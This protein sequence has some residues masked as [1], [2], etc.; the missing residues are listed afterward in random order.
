MRRA[1]NT[2]PPKKAITSEDLGKLLAIEPSMG[3]SEI[4]LILDNEA[5]ETDPS[6]GLFCGIPQ[7][8]KFQHWLSTNESELLFVQDN[9]ASLDPKRAS[10]LSVFC[11]GLTRNLRE[12]HAVISIQFFCGHHAMQ[13]SN[14][15]L[16]GPAGLIRS[17]IFQ[18]IR[19]SGYASFDLGFLIPSKARSNIDKGDVP[20]LCWVFEKLVK[21][22]PLDTLLFCFV[23][24][25]SFFEG[26][27]YRNETMEAIECLQ[28]I[29]QDQKLPSI[30]KLMITH[31]S[32]NGHRQYYIDPQDC[33]LLS[34]QAEFEGYDLTEREIA[35]R[36]RRIR[37]NEKASIEGVYGFSGSE[38]DET[39]CW[40]GDL[41]QD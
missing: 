14:N 29:V 41:L 7:D 4:D 13:E 23:D 19:T 34:R 24:G 6:Q 11:A 9:I 15:P 3:E 16:C 5:T 32:P 31:L 36:V 26:R 33:L 2:P 10:S 40:N 21:Q 35:A 28:R 22:L 20:T 17:L 25:L 27:A 12:D 8:K 37:V 1:V 18:L 38:E 30:F 39:E